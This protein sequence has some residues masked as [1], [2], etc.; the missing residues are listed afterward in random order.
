MIL[1]ALLLVALGAVLAGA[2]PAAPRGPRVLF[3]CTGNFYR[4]RF[5]EAVFNEH[6]PPG[7]TAFS[8][9]LDT[10]TPRTTPVSPLVS[11]E[12][13]RRRIDVARAGAAPQPLT[14]RDLDEADLV[15]LMNGPEHAPALRRQFPG[16]SFDKVRTWA[17]PD[18]PKLAAAE[19]FKAMWRMTTALVAE[20]AAPKRP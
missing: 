18:V 2:E 14:Q 3:V 6:P 15:V 5:A 16:F 9:G 8:R 11:A 20:L 7:W 12:L 17:V 13:R 10:S 4:S 19:A 1:R